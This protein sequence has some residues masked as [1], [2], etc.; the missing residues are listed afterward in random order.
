MDRIGIRVRIGTNVDAVRT[1]DSWILCINRIFIIISWLR[2]YCWF[3]LDLYGSL[4]I[5]HLIYTEVITCDV[6]SWT[7][8]GM[9][10]ELRRTRSSI[11]QRWL[12][13]QHSD[14]SF[15]VLQ[16][17]PEKRTVPHYPTVTSGPSVRNSRLLGSKQ[18]HEAKMMQHDWRRSSRISRRKNRQNYLPRDAIVR[19]SWR[20]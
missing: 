5:W 11:L 1:R 8:Y 18:L 13:T 4:S 6:A 16:A 15:G 7:L 12:E 17:F 3:A 14:I 10:R 19:E 20:D 2:L 9:P